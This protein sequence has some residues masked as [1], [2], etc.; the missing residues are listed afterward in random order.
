MLDDV[1]PSHACPRGVR[2]EIRA[3]VCLAPK[4]GRGHVAH[5]EMLDRARSIPCLENVK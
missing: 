1:L 5:L 3:P 4:R 2:K